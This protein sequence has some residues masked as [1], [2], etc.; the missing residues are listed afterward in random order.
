MVWNRYDSLN[1]AILGA[2]CAA[3]LRRQSRYMKLFYFSPTPFNHRKTTPLGCTQF[4][5]RYHYILITCFPCH[6]HTDQGI[7]NRI[8]CKLHSL[9][10]AI[11]LEGNNIVRIL[12]HQRQP[13]H[14]KLICFPAGKTQLLKDILQECSGIFSLYTK[15]FGEIK[16]CRSFPFPV[17]IIVCLSLHIGQYTIRRSRYHPTIAICWIGTGQ[18]TIKRKVDWNLCFFFWI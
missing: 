9:G 3:L 18:F 1:F 16:L 8:H 15:S 7:W 12:L 5:L 11:V 6:K 17:Q 14:D 2:K 13:V 4:L 10:I